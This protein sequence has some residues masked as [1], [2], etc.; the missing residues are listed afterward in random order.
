VRIFS[1]S[2]PPGVVGKRAVVGCGTMIAPSIAA[3][4]AEFNELTGARLA[5]T[6]IET[7]FGAR[8]NAS[9]LLCGA[10]T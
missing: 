1:S 4:A 8:V 3:I 7:R 6:A 2:V 9:G 5:V 10:T